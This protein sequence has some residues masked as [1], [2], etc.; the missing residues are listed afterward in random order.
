[1]GVGREFASRAVSKAGWRILPL[2]GL[3]YLIAYM[4][5]VNVSFAATQMNSDLGFSAT[6]YGLG[7]GMFFLSYALF[8]IP[9]NLLLLRFGARRWIA[10]IM[11]SWG[12]L[13]AMMMFVTTPFE[14]YL[15]RFLIGAAEAGF[16]PGAIFYLSGWFPG[17]QRGRAVSL[18]YLFGPLS[19]MVMGWLSV[20]L[21]TFD[22]TAGMRGW[23]WLFL[24]EGLPAA[25]LG[26]VFLFALPDAPGGAKWLSGEE[27]GAL[28]EA[29]ERER[30]RP[31]EPSTHRIM[32]ILRDPTVVLLA[33]IGACN[34]STAVTVYL[35]APLFL[36]EM[37]GRSAGQI[38]TLVSTGGLLA[39]LAMALTGWITDR[40]GERFSAMLAGQAVKIC[41]L[42]MIP[43]APSAMMAFGGYLVFAIGS[44]STQAANGALWGDLLTER[45]LAIGAAAINTAAQLAAFFLPYA[46]GALR[47][48]TGS[49][50]AGLLVLPGMVMFA[51]LVTLVLWQRV[52]T[53]A[54]TA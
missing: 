27:R 19:S 47:D 32:D 42:L 35:S 37:T 4:D 20:W 11:I 54:Q 46:F 34:I 6:V 43:F 41:G 53:V 52:N 14:F 22:G 9:S 48:T 36:M 45:R 1:M 31:G 2:L 13:S 21:L 24:V 40:R 5:R 30:L 10:R 33:V 7:A 16:F 3:A 15:L 50:H 44:W 8:E 18:F 28:I 38:G 29:L 39:A 51:M 12:L 26:I 17:A 25:T 49:Y 23:Q